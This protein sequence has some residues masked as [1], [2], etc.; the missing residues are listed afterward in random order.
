MN[1]NDIEIALSP[2]GHVYLEHNNWQS[3][4]SI[5]NE[6]TQQISQFFNQ[7]ATYGL[8]H[9]G[10]QNFSDLPPDFTFWQT[11]ARLFITKVCKYPE[12][13]ELKQLP[14]ITPPSKLELSEIINQA[15][16]I[17]GFEYLTIEA[18]S[19]IWL[20]L[21]ETL[22]NELDKYAGSIPAYLQ[23]YNQN[24]NTVGRVCFHLAENKNNPDK[25]F[26]FVATYT[27][28]L[29]EKATAQHLL[30]W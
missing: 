16:F 22:T 23:S 29:N 30:R 3:D 9:L 27:T 6:T 20:S 14:S 1:N 15:P 18:L 21:H 13:S 17:R 11:F 25:P 19:K 5:I 8:L 24:W 7:S 28:K 2:E 4:H 26:A 12:L 10:I